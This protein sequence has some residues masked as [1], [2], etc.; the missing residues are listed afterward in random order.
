[1]F[2]NHLDLHRMMLADSIRTEAYR[3]AIFESIRKGDI[4]IDIGT[5]TGVLAFFACQAGAKKV[6]AIENTDI[7]EFAKQI[8]KDNNMLDKI[9]F[10]KEHS[11]AV[12]L[13]EKGNVI[14]SETLGTFALEENVLNILYDA[15]KRFLKPN[16]III[17]CS[18][19]IFAVPV[20]AYDIYQKIDIWKKDLY[21]INFSAI[22]DMTM[23]NYYTRR[24]ESK[25]LLCNPFPLDH[26]N[27]KKANKNVI[28]GAVTYLVKKEG[29]LH[30]LAGW[31][32]V[33][34]SKNIALS[35]SPLLPSTHW[36]NI[37]FP[38]QRPTPVRK[39][40]LIKVNI[41]GKPK[42]INLTW[43]VTVINKGGP[44]HP[45]QKI[46]FNHSTFKG[47][48]I[49]LDTLRDLKDSS[50]GYKPRL[51]EE[52]EIELLILNLCNGEKTIQEIAQELKRKY[53]LRYRNIKEAI[54][55]VV[56]VMGK[57]STDKSIG[58]KRKGF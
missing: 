41:I 56:T 3:K 36:E 35:N 10:I 58:N 49:S 20:E 33:Q 22:R 38:I 52:G 51:S 48:P 18:I 14:I 45:S 46:Y 12:T 25:Y 37:F 8:A 50:K 31:F 13:P 26:F 28:N 24:I 17:P 9:V 29:I 16:G 32:N 19:D 7:I 57:Y 53:P 43:E 47:L 55:K 21:K 34:L 44:S 11:M 2:Y 40:D 4:I 30:G 5:G 23:N 27:L 39:G 6:Y 1:M 15:K 42:G 54:Y